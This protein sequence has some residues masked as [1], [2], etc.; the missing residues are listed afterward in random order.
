MLPFPAGKHQTSLCLGTILALNF[1]C[2]SPCGQVLLP[3]LWGR[4]V[5]TG[6]H[7]NQLS[8]F[9]SSDLPYLTLPTCL[10]WASRALCP[11]FA[12]PASVDHSK[13]T[14]CWW[15]GHSH[16]PKHIF[17]LAFFKKVLF[18]HYLRER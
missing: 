13:G 3:H 1:S 11:R 4:G 8:V 12:F 14:D 2:P 16:Q 5:Q 7:Q 15:S 17:F 9:M 18:I 6:G 10:P